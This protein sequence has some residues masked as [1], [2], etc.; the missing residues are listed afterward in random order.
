M[1]LTR[2][3]IVQIVAFSAFVTGAVLL[4]VG[5]AGAAT[6]LIVVGILLVMTSGAGG[7]MSSV[8]HGHTPISRE[9]PVASAAVQG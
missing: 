3:N 6:P 9:N 2:K 1:A 8:N 7:L 4:G 5:S